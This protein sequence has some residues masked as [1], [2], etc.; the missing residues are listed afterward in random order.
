M[1]SLRFRPAVISL[2]GRKI[3]EISDSTYTNMANDENQYGIE[4]VIGQSDGSDEVKLD[5]GTVT[6][7]AGHSTTLK[8]IIANK[9]NATYT[10]K[11]DGGFEQFDGR[12]TQREYT[13]DSKTGTCKGK[14]SVIGGRP[15]II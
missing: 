6:P 12:M 2:N 7:V 11:V 14:F 13:S 1:A 9:R 5:F 4:G 8:D 10:V 3:A 15:T